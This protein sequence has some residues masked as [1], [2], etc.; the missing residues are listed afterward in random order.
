MLFVA[1]GD[2]RWAVSLVTLV[3]ACVLLA[4]APSVAFGTTEEINE[5][6]KQQRALREKEERL[7]DERSDAEAEQEH[8]NAEL[9]RTTARLEEVRA[10]LAV[11]AERVAKAT[12]EVAKLSAERDR[13][14][15]LASARVRQLYMAGA[16]D[17][18]LSLLSGTSTDE[19]ADRSHYLSAVSEQDQ[20]ALERLAATATRLQR[21]QRDLEEDQQRMAR[22][23]DELRVANAELEEQMKKAVA[24]EERLTALYTETV[25]EREELAAEERELR[26]EQAAASRARTSAASAGASSG[27]GSAAVAASSGGMACPQAQPRSF[28]NTWGAPR[29]GGRSHKGT[30]I[31]GARGGNVYAI[32]SG[33]IQF[34]KVGGT[35][36][37]FLSLR[38][39]DGN[40]YWY[41]HLQDFVAGAGQ[42]VQAGQ[43]IAHNGDTGNARGTTPHIHFELHPGGG[44][45]V[46]PYPLLRRVCG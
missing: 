4:L 33:T 32:T 6:E 30:D 26:A 44:G 9:Q 46:N 14:H 19:L 41:M 2:R 23:E 22:L 25:A 18:L 42:R 11:V 28:T 1:L 8:V 39:D 21:R 29:S 45:A 27:G 36:G 3:V 12:D 31:M 38:G 7:E 35:A 10:D 17:P 40:T 34:T 20:A 13:Q 5:L 16:K 37:L 15:D 24:A 43:L